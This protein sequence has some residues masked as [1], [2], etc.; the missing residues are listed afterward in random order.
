MLLP[1]LLRRGGELDPYEQLV[2]LKDAEDEA[3]V[4]QYVGK[5]TD[6]RSQEK[7]HHNYH[8]CILNLLA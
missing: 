7:A 3:K 5:R 6:R 4:V 1:T 8:Q 2:H